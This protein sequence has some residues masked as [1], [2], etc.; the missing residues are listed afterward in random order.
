[1]NQGLGNFVQNIS[2]GPYDYEKDQA[3]NFV[4]DVDNPDLFSI[5]PTVSPKGTL[6]YQLAPD[7][8]GSTTVSIY[9]KDDGGVANGGKDQSETKTFQI[10]IR[11][12]NDPP[13][14]NKGLDQSVV[15][16]A[17]LQTIPHWATRIIKGPADEQNQKLTFLVDVDREDIFEQLPEISADGTLS[18]EPAQDAY[19]HALVKVRLKDDGGTENGG[20]DISAEQSFT[21]SI[22]WANHAP[23]FSKGPDIQIL[24]DA[25]AQTY[26]DWAT[27]IKAGPDEEDFQAVYFILSVEQPQLFEELPVISSKG[28]LSFRT[29]PDIN[30]KTLV[31]VFL[32]DNGGTEFGGQDQS[33]TQFFHINIKPVNDPPVFTPGPD[34]TVPQSSEPQLV[35]S[36]ANNISCG[37][38]DESEQKLIFLVST[39]NE[40]FFASPPAILSNGSLYYTL[41]ANAYGKAILS[42]ALQDN[43]GTYDNGDD[44]SDPVIFMITVIAVNH[45]PSFTPGDSI[46]IPEDSGEVR[47]DNWATEISP[48]PPEELY[49]RVQFYA[50]GIPPTLFSKQPEM[51]SDGTLTFETSPDVNG[52]VNIRIYLKDDG[53][54][55]N[56][57][58]D[59]SEDYY[60]DVNITP[61]NDAPRP[62]QNIIVIEE[63]TPAAY[64]LTAID[65]ENDPVT[66]EIFLPPQKGTLIIEN[67]ITGKCVYSPYTD[68][69]GSDFFQFQAFDHMAQ[70]EPA[71]VTIQI[72]PVND[73]PI[74][75][76]I[77][78]Q[79]TLEDT[80]TSPIEFYISDSDSSITDLQLFITSS[81]ETLVPNTN[82]KVS[83]I[84]AKRSLII[85][86]E[87]NQFGRSVIT[88]RVA[89]NFNLSSQ[90]QFI[91]EVQKRNDPPTLSVIDDQMI[92][93]DQTTP[94]IMFSVHDSETPVGNLDIQV[95]ISE[96]QM[97][98]TENIQLSGADVI[99]TMTLKPFINVSGDVHVTVSVYDEEMAV[100]SQSFVLHILAVDDPPKIGN[101]SNQTIIEDEPSQ[102]I[103]FEISD[104]DTPL[105]DISVRAVSSDE[106][107]IANDQ[108]IISG[109]GM[110]RMI[111][112]TP[113][114]D[115]SG[116]VRIDLI[117]N[118]GFSDSEIKSFNVMITPV[119][120]PPIADAGENFSIGESRTVYL[121]ASKSIDPENNIIFYQWEQITG[122][123]VNID[124]RTESK[125][126]FTAPEVGPNG[127]TLVFKLLV[128]DHDGQES[129]DTIEISIEDMA[130]QYLIEA[131]NGNNGTIEPSGQLFV[132]EYSSKSFRIIPQVNYDIQDVLINGESIGPVAEYTFYDIQADQTIHAF[133]VARP[134]ITVLAEG[135]G[136]VSPQ[137]N[138]FVN[139]GDNLTVTFLPDD[140]HILD[141]LLVDDIVV[142]PKTAFYFS[143]I[144]F[145][146]TLTAFF[147]SKNIYVETETGNRGTVEPSG[148]I[149]M[150]SGS[151]LTIQVI[152]D[153]GY[154]VADVQVNGTSI[155]AVTSHTL[156]N[157][158]ANTHV[159]ANFQPIVAQTITASSGDNGHI[160]PEGEIK[161][162][163]DLAQSFVMI[164]DETYLVADVLIDNVSMGPME[165]YTFPSVKRNYNIH[166]NFEHQPKITSQ[167]G[168]NGK[169]EPN[170]EI[171]VK[172]GW[173]QEF[174]ITPDTNYE[175]NDVIVNGES[176]GA[177]SGHIFLEINDDLSI[178]AEFQSMPKIQTTTNSHGTITPSGPIIL[179]SN[180]FQQFKIIPDPGYQL[181]KLF[182][183]GAPYPMPED[184][185]LYTLS[186]ITKNYSLNAQFTL[187]QYTIN[188]SS[189]EFGSITPTG[190]ITV[191]GKDSLSYL[192]IP[193]PGYE[194]GSV[195]VDHINMGRISAY[196]FKSI[197]SDHTVHVEFIKKPMIIAESGKHGQIDPEG[198]IDVPNGGYQMFLIKPDKGYKIAS[199]M[200]DDQPLSTQMDVIEADNLWKSYVFANV[201]KNHTISASF[202]RCHIELRTNG[203]GKITPDKDLEFDVLDNVCFTFQ[204]N[205]G[206]I[207]DNVIVDKEP[208]GPET[209]YNFWELTADH[210]LEVNFLAIEIQTITITANPGGHITP[211]GTIE[212]MGGEYAEFMVAPDETHFLSE[213]LLNGTPISDSNE[214][215]KMLPVGKEGFY[216]S[217]NVTSDQTIEA[218]FEEI[219]KYEIRAI[220]GNNGKIIP[221][222][223]I[224][225]LHGQYQLF[226]FQPNPGYAVK[227]VQLDSESQ[228]QINSFSLSV[229]NNHI[230]TVSFYPINTCIIEGTVVD[231]D[232][233][234]QG[235]ENFT[236]EVWLGDNLLQTTTTNSNGEY[237]FENLPAVEHLVMAAWPPF[238]SSNY[239]G[240]FFNEKKERM[241]A[242]HLSTLSGNLKDIQFRMQRTFEEGIRGQV[243]MG[244]K[245][246]PFIVVDVFE[247]SA[248]FVKNVTTDENGFY[249]LTGLDPSEDYKVSVWYRPYATEYFYSISDFI[250][251]G[252]IIPTYSVLSWD[253]AKLF[254][255]QY[256]PLSNIDIIIDPGAT[257]S[258]TVLLPDGS[259][260]SGIRVN[261][262]SDKDQSGNGALTDA[263]GRYTIIG[264]TEILPE[265]AATDGYIV[266][267]KA[268][269]YPYIAYP[270]ATSEYQ[271]L[272]VATGRTDIDFQFEKGHD[273]S[274]TIHFADGNP[275][276]DIQ[277]YAWS[278]KHP[279]NKSGSAIS[280]HFGNYTI[281][282][283]PIASDYV[284]SVISDQYPV[285]YFMDA[286][287]IENAF[288]LN[289]LEHSLKDI[290]FT[291]K[292]GSFIHGFV[293]MHQEI[294]SEKPLSGIWVNIW[295]ESTQTGG[296]VVTDDNGYY[297][298]TGLVAEA[299]DYKISVIH[300]GYQPAFYKEMLDDN[301]MNDTVYQWNDAG[302]VVPS[303]EEQ[304][305]FRNIVLTKGVTFAGMVTFNN[306]PIENVTVEIFSDETGGWGKSVSNNRTDANM[307][308]TGLIP[309]IYTV[310]AISE[311][312]A[313]AI[314]TGINLEQSI[315]DYNIQL[316][317]PDRTISGTLIGLKKGEIVR[318]DAWSNDTNYYGFAEV[319]G[320]GF[321]THFKIDGLK[322]ASDYLLEAFC[323]N[324]PRQIYDGCSDI[325]SADLVDISMHD[326]SSVVFRF[327]S[328]GTFMIHG[329][330][331]FPQDVQTGE[332]IQVEAW[333]ES[334]DTIIET[335]LMY[336]DTIVIPY[337][338]VGKAPATD[339]QVRIHSNQFIDITRKDPVNVVEKPVITDVNFMLSRGTQISGRITNA[340]NLGMN[341][342]T[343]IA[344]SDTLKSGA[345]VSSFPDG[346][347]TI[348]GLAYASDYYIE[349]IHDDLGHY[350]Y[351]TQQTVR[352]HTQASLLDNRMG[353]ISEIIIVIPEGVSIQGY[354]SDTQSKKLA[355]I[356]VEAW[357]ASTH[358]GNG[359]F[360]DSNG[361]YKIQGL[362][363]SNDYV[364]R[365]LPEQL[366]LPDEKQ[367]ISAP[368]DALDFRLDETNGFRVIGT[369]YNCDEKP[370]QLARVEFQSANNQSAYGFAMTSSDGSYEVKHIPPAT[371]YIVTVLPPKNSQSAF[372]RL[373]NLSISS[374][375]ILDIHLEPE[376]MF[377]GT[378]TDQTTNAP[379]KNA[380][381]VVFSASTGFWDETQSNK[382][383]IYELHHVSAGSDYM[384]IVNAQD[385][386]E[387]KKTALTPGV[388]INFVLETGGVI[389]GVVKL[390]NT[391][392]GMPDVPVE[393]YSVS[394]AGLS[395][396]GGIA[397]TDANGYFQIGQLKINDHQ[398]LP[399]DDYVVFIYPENY[400]PQSRGNK[401]TGEIVNFV[402]AGGDANVTSG[403]VPAFSSEHR[404]IIDVFE[405]NGT[406]VTCVK[407]SI[408][409]S[410]IVPGLH[411]NKKYQYRFLFEFPK[412]GESI[413]QWAGENDIGVDNREDAFAYSVPS[414]IDFE[415]QS[416]RRKRKENISPLIGGPGPVQNLRSSSHAF[417]T[418]NRRKRT[419]TA[420]GPETVSNDPSVSVG[421][422]PP[423]TDTESLAGYYGF[424]TDASDFTF[425]KFNT[426]NQSP[427]RTRKITSRDLEGDDV[428][429]YFHVAA[430]DIQGRVGETSSIAFRIDTVPPTNVSVIAPDFSE[431]RNIQLQLG[432]GGASEMYIS[433]ESYQ[434]GG[435]W[436]KLSQKR[437]WQLSSG[438]GEKPVY[439]SFRDRAGNISQSMAKTIYTQELPKY[440]IQ[441]TSGEYGRISPSGTI[442]KEKGEN[443]SMVIIPEKNYQ[444]MRMTL[445]GK[446]LSS[447]ITSY[448][449][450]NIQ[451]DHLIAV[452]F[453]KA[454]FKI[455]TSAG[456]HGQISPDGEMFVEKGTSQSFMITPD[457]GYAVDQILFDM[458]PVSWTG[459]PFII[460]DIEKGHQLFVT[461]TRSYT[462]TTTVDAHGQMIPN[463]QLLVA[464]GHQQQFEMIPEKGYDIDRVLIDGS[465]VDIY[466]QSLTLYNVQ[467]TY[468]IQVFF[469]KAFFSIDSI[470][471]Q[472][473]MIEPEGNLIVAK[474]DQQVFNIL[475]DNGF[476]IEKLIIDGMTIAQSKTYTFND[477]R[478]NHSIAASFHPKQFIVHTDSGP[479]GFVTPQ[480]D[481]AVNWGEEVILIVEA[482]SNYAVDEVLLD[483]Q[484]VTLTAGYYYTLTDIHHHHDFYVTF[485]RV[486]Q[487]VSIVSGEG[488]SN[489]S[490]IVMVEQ[491]HSQLFELIPGRGYKLEK[492][493]VDDKYVSIN[494]LFYMFDNITEDHQ[495][496]TTFAPIPI[497]ITATS[498]ANGTIS[499]SGIISYDMFRKATFFLKAD[500]GFE[501]ASLRVNGNN[502]PYTKNSY[503]IPSVDQTYDISVTYELFNY[504]PIVSDANVHLVEDSWVCGKLN[505]KD[506]DGDQISFEIVNMPAHGNAV[507]TN[508]SDGF[509]CYTP[510]SNVDETD[511]FVF[512]AKDNGKN[513]N[514]GIVTLKIQSQNDA[515]QAID[516]QWIATEDTLLETQLSAMDIDAD[517]IS[518]SIVKQATLG[519]AILLDSST[520]EIQYQPKPDVNGLDKIQFQVSDGR[521]LS[522]IAEISIQIHPVNDAPIAYSSTIET[523]RGQALAI[524]LLASDRENDL[525]DYQIVS[526]PVAGIL[527][528]ITGGMYHYQ[529]DSDFIGKDQL[530]FQV[531][532]GEYTS[533]KATVSII[534]GTINVITNEETAVTLNVAYGA[535]IIKNVSH[536]STQWHNQ[537][538]TYTPSKDFVGYD[539]I[540][541]KNPNDAVIREI[542]IRIEPVNDP[543]VIHTTDTV[544]VMGEDESQ[545]IPI[546]I[547]E[548]DGDA[549]TMTYTS[550]E[551]GIIVDS[552]GLLTYYPNENYHGSDQFIVHVTDGTFDVTQ[553]INISVISKNDLPVIGK[554]PT[555]EV[556]EDHA[557]DI[558]IVAT[559]VDQD[560]LVLHIIE[561][562]N[563]GQIQGKTLDMMQLNY[564]PSPNFEGWDHFSISVFDS[565]AHSETKQISI[566]VMSVNDSPTAN[567]MTMNGIENT[568]LIV[569]LEGFDIE[570]QSLVYQVFTQAENGL[571]SITPSTGECVYM[572]SEDF[573]GQDEFSFTVNDGYTSSA[574]ATVIISVEMGN[575]PPISENGMLEMIEDESG[576]YTL[577]ATDINNDPLFFK[578]ITQPTL[579]QVQMIDSQTGRCKYIP[580]PNKNGTDIFTFIVS[581]GVLDSSIATITVEILP[582]NDRPQ[583]MDSTLRMDEDFEKQ[584]I[585]SASDIDGDE[586]IYEIVVNPEQGVLELINPQNGKYRYSPFLDYHGT[587]QFQFIAR[588]ANTTSLTATVNIIIDPIN[589][590]PIA[591]ALSIETL[592]DIPI[593]GSFQGTDIDNDPLSFMLVDDPNAVSIGILA[594][595]DAIK[596]TFTYYPPKNQYGQY[597]F[598]YYVSDGQLT[599]SPVPLTI[600]ILP[601]NDAP[602]VFDQDLSTDINEPLIIYLSGYDI[603]ENILAYQVVTPPTN[604]HLKI[605]NDNWQY[606]PTT[607]FQGIDFFTYQANDQTG[608]DTA[609]S[610]IG[611]INIRVGVP[612]ADFFT[613]EDNKVSL[614]L[615]SIT[616]FDSAVLQYEIIDS[617]DHGL[618]KGEG[619]FQ[620]YEPEMNYSEMDNFSVRYT[621][622]NQTHDR[623]IQVYI[624]PVND[625]P[626]LTGFEPSPA[627][628]YEDQ[629]LTL[630]MIV[631][632]P[633]TSLDA[634]TF[635][636]KNPPVNGQASF[637]G[638]VLSYQPSQDFSGEDQL[639]IS[640]TD[641][642]INAS[643][644]QKIDITI[645]PANDAPIAFDGKVETLEETQV[646]I[647]PVAFDQDTDTLVYTIKQKPEHGS[648]LG[649][650]P[651]FTYVPQTNFYGIDRLTFV[652]NDGESMSEEAE[653]R[654]H[655]ANVNDTPKA[656]SASFV[657]YDGNHVSGRLLALD[658]DL[659][660]LI[661]S[662]VKQPEK[663]LLTLINP[664]MGTFVYYPHTGESG[665]D[666]FSFKVNDGSKDSNDASVSITL[667][668]NTTENQ[669]ANVNIIINEPYEPYVNSCT[670]M[671]IDADS[672]QMIV[673][674]STLKDRIDVVL[675]KGN[676]RLIMLALNYKP[677]EYQQKD[678]Q[679]FFHLDDDI[680]LDITLTPQESFDPHPAGV[681]ISYMTTPNGIKI[682]AVKK[683][684]DADDQFYMHIQTRSGE[685]PVSHKDT[686]GD[687]S[688]NAPYTYYWTPS[689][690]WSNYENSKY[691]ISFIFYGGAYGY[692][693]PLDTITIQ[694]NENQNRKR[695]ISN[696]DAI[697]HEFGQSPMYISQ[698]DSEFYP[699]AGTDCHA[700]LMDNNEIERHM[701]IH[702][703][704]IPLEYL[705]IDDS[706][707]YNGGQLNYH[708]QTDRFHP[709]PFQ[710]LQ[711]VAPDQKLR[712]EI[713]YYTFSSDKAGNGIS[714]S[715]YIAEGD[716][717]GKP[718]RYNPI[719]M[720]DS[721]RMSNAPTI[722]LPVYLNLNAS[723]L[724]GITNLQDISPEVRIHEVGD[725]VD[726]F[727]TEQLKTTVENDGLVYIEMNHLT[728]VGLD[729]FIADTPSPS[730]DSDHDS[731]GCFVD[732]LQGYR[733]HE[734]FGL[735]II[736]FLIGLILLLKVDA[737]AS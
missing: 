133:F 663:G 622:A 399:I 170:G 431:Q 716:L 172:K 41:A 505:G 679:K 232:V 221:S 444:I 288:L 182:V 719:L 677:Y 244:N 87:P 240:C 583:A 602:V 440:T 353:D 630:T 447:N 430:V 250:E 670:Y 258:G 651:P 220:S 731:S 339:Y 578:I 541:Y 356:W 641:G 74:I 734:I 491:N 37:P 323:D 50:F 420:S 657:A 488:Q 255:S 154:E 325:L 231:R 561:Y 446:A 58:I 357:S 321:A 546:V 493:Q 249:T 436:E 260:A 569:Q 621:L 48:G 411:V 264:L 151:D 152:P 90:V 559:D 380:T 81:N 13:T 281:A 209:F 494:N 173:Y 659:D 94:P 601:A 196:T 695:T 547:E 394:N 80:P 183:N 326:I 178:V 653:I 650:S 322:P 412:S 177:V 725:G 199:L 315:M 638:N 290:N 393:V 317:K 337:T 47:F 534:I 515:P 100:A 648:L 190:I 226:T 514:M 284:V 486:H 245:G 282:N 706:Y 421:W 277:V 293:Y 34:L 144:Q 382:D 729:M 84:L 198:V 501:V 352:E 672:G 511:Q 519:Q 413:V 608:S 30:G 342:L 649:Q 574:P 438:N 366:F 126:F 64:T 222:G 107:K 454:L 313:D 688:S 445:D 18:Y 272:R 26:D 395:N 631:V 385:Y 443:L 92:Y 466:E 246:V 214:D 73:A 201:D 481:I 629:A 510:N 471:G 530:T 401:K 71:T 588:D 238:E 627:L 82:M 365:A 527:T 115:Q 403:T 669:F 635:S 551:N 333:S 591:T 305:L 462:I 563:H 137:G 469:K 503:V 5:L 46:T 680:E 110:E 703:P 645:A 428:N 175:V 166:V 499:P 535:T 122:T 592:E 660:I 28:K 618:L 496:I 370:L 369:I 235:L 77:S 433:S 295:S 532:D 135:N 303:I 108:I 390:A 202:N 387:S 609:I 458:T 615:L 675:P 350:Y 484:P 67:P 243:R 95:E 383:G 416:E 39:E 340:Q 165:R 553:E 223:K 167:A 392:K 558:T 632:D 192:F 101:L 123:Q 68:S 225:V 256:P 119:N 343:V 294:G 129:E 265:Q 455:V 710:T 599:S 643:S 565:L 372:M 112:F 65:I 737:R 373:K 195:L 564:S 14:F 56:G 23:S 296:D 709:D 667:D 104:P 678:K 33:D 439:V 652:A 361:F 556:L 291:L 555:V 274:G 549:I 434:E 136:Q 374:D 239:Y 730:S 642:F 580:S 208:Q 336:S 180:S 38:P 111:Q 188:A 702:I 197:V 44:T 442:I 598:N 397:T 468:D 20:K 156:K 155:G 432:A 186:N 297:E 143:D 487:I 721:S 184:Q 283:L 671:F 32:K 10:T 386:L 567:S 359:V 388:D 701:T 465:P 728:M 624:I 612:E 212:I 117:A 298:I 681:D 713:N 164:P 331:T 300:Q 254:R 163:D 349:I 577:T 658:A 593:S 474:N 63:D 69:V 461:F 22:I 168:P 560:A 457:K 398:R 324:Y 512:M 724:S 647:T 171:Y 138:V 542:V 53:G 616:N 655:V 207:I 425:S 142:A 539:T 576:F 263:A 543:P 31:N 406:F 185:C 43:G 9:L 531:N 145:D 55:E 86:P 158:R 109:Q 40:G 121:D 45:A 262:S 176:I 346:S 537:E 252:E 597:R 204:P 633:D 66:Y 589:D 70:S 661:Y 699:L 456:N 91:L 113:L 203:N 150:T 216:V 665:I 533:N 582:I 310:R 464:E 105:D 345:Q 162:S 570:A 62:V 287:Q 586:L 545:P 418:I 319:K 60:L 687:G 114:Q 708:R 76:E 690:P 147:I 573:V 720:S 378:L 118:D 49:Q 607:D 696:T 157:I 429:Y 548:P 125:T 450:D 475:P 233:T 251:P 606:I 523:G 344:W 575:R 205:D 248:T 213:I 619:Q 11:P 78:T 482:A 224:E 451:D 348:S 620:A 448:T 267:V 376:L 408:D 492:L 227:D 566:H 7:K 96:A 93:E 424:F 518:Y 585:L 275:A 644:S 691:E 332:S 127:T 604:G 520:G 722:V 51:F 88:V 685:I 396:F 423:A 15:K 35:T 278:Q 524:T 536:G 507:I 509:F 526:S 579:G 467:K 441:L 12:V 470:S 718:V 714:L 463:G 700:T 516:D 237:I 230:I 83:G 181:Y 628:T 639:M 712:V 242:D 140:A 103:L 79:T 42:V 646:T 57:G 219:P 626:K 529:P 673:N 613:Y 301:L 3:L 253:R 674:G 381:V 335:E 538:L 179:P 634:L 460:S 161:V 415:L 472:H 400:P 234:T 54:I 557:V 302:S 568:K 605:E 130:G 478:S 611:S 610:N 476:E 259:P 6:N 210:I 307:I 215:N 153:S 193:D 656:N 540:R 614:D 364:V 257:I 355:G 279:E 269:D 362:S 596:G 698:G 422:D 595:Q 285:H 581:D 27:N 572:P 148:R 174:S 194:I 367:N 419:I 1:M 120:D 347:F 97:I 218:I 552:T 707:G 452:T 21:I 623:K 498:S 692:A 600:N 590:A 384:V 637:M 726:G 544:I 8:N 704:P 102:E 191:S 483:N 351:N 377:S 299:D 2:P 128:I 402:V 330:V 4:L 694:W 316:T 506:G 363:E 375:R 426:D 59:K 379:I 276:Q 311:G 309:G 717:A 409:R 134:K 508:A 106:T 571:V 360:T 314:I 327:E 338:L 308:I 19:G 229:M 636:V 603:D 550:P 228:G 334:T 686:S 480:G 654:I 459:N 485:K 528:P 292:K 306:Q 124:N 24:E 711:T 61:V 407:A 584:N 733:W 662:L 594:I 189:G 89:D 99:R 75:S 98:P 25:P 453:E 490:G 72:L 286:H 141:Y 354:V 668:S 525:L 689:S 312:F 29:K 617:P 676:Y 427:I 723:L 391:G 160:S 371:D 159:Y 666:T 479:N 217:L 664:V 435:M 522:N 682:W 206:F 715:F 169:I 732:G 404:A 513:S 517:P 52:L 261:A 736:C 683:N 273:I 705:Y 684:L 328:Q 241:D 640:V 149:L 266:E 341:Q 236:V 368:C 405:N 271:A 625:P 500:P 200:V 318:I 16:N 211:S 36:W 131:L 304:S 504:P 146:H 449:F 329:K 497:K 85:T 358:S 521:L 477:I 554:L 289:L 139:R 735:I 562:P 417:Q 187:D 270:Q 320:S 587:D 495:L 489:P 437:E 697:T 414:N 132:K 280:D 116:S 410:F 693:K 473:G 389:S 727:R 17:R 502:M 247:D 268:V